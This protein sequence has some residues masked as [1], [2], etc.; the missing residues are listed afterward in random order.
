MDSDDEFLFLAGCIID[1]DG[2]LHA[3]H[4]GNV[5]E[6]TEDV[7]GN[8]AI[9]DLYKRHKISS[10]KRRLGELSLLKLKKG[11][12]DADYNCGMCCD[13]LKLLSDVTNCL[14]AGQLQSIEAIGF[15]AFLHSDDFYVPKGFI[16]WICSQF[17]VR[18]S[19]LVLKDKVIPFSKVTVHKILG[20][21]I[22]GHKVLFDSE[23][24]EQ[25]LLQMLDLRNVES[26]K[27]FGDKLVAKE[28]LSDDQFVLCFMVIAISSLFC[29]NHTTQPVTEALAAFQD[30]HEVV[31]FDWAL[32]VHSK[33]IE[34]VTTFPKLCCKP[35]EDSYCF[36]VCAY[37]LAVF[38]LDCV[39][40]GSY[41]VSQQIPRISFW[42]RSM[43]Y[44]NNVDINDLRVGNSCSCAEFK[45]ILESLYGSV[46]PEELKL[47]VCKI[48]EDHCVQQAKNHQISS[49]ELIL[50]IFS[51]CNELSV[52]MGNDKFG[53]SDGNCHGSKSLYDEKD[54][55]GGAKAVH[56]SFQNHD[57][58]C[59]PVN[60]ENHL[61]QVAS[62]DD[63]VDLSLKIGVQN[64]IANDGVDAVEVNL[65]E[66]CRPVID[67]STPGFLNFGNKHG[68]G[69]SS[70]KVQ[71]PVVKQKRVA[72]MQTFGNKVHEFD[73]NRSVSYSDVPEMYLHTPQDCFMPDITSSSGIK[74]APLLFGKVYSS[75]GA[76]A[77]PEANPPVFDVET[78]Q[79]VRNRDNNNRAN[80]K[81]VRKSEGF[82]RD[83]DKCD[84]AIPVS[85]CEMKKQNARLCKSTVGVLCASP[86]VPEQN[87]FM[88]MGQK[89]VN[90]NPVGYSNELQCEDFEALN[91]VDCEADFVD[92]HS[93]SM[94]S[95]VDQKKFV[96]V[97]DVDDFDN[98][99]DVNGNVDDDVEFVR[100]V[101]FESKIR[102]L[103]NK[104]EMLDNRTC[105]PVSKS[106]KVDKQK[107][108]YLAACRLASSTR[109]ND[110]NAVEI[111]GCF[112][113][114]RELGNSLRTG[115]KVGSYVINAL[116]RKFFLDKRPTI[117]RKHYF[118]S[119]I[120]AILLKG[121]GNLS[122]V[123][124]CFDGAASVLELHKADM[125]LFPICH[126]D[127]WFVFIV[128][129]KNSLFVFLDSYYSEEDDY[130]IFVRSN[131]IP[132]F[133]RIWKELVTG[134]LDFENY[135]VVYPAVPKQS[136]ITDCGVFVIM[137]LTFWTWYCG[138]CIEFTQ[139]DIDNIRIHTVSDLVC[140][141]H[142]V[143]HS[144]PITNYFGE[145]SFPRVGEIRKSTVQY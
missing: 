136:N 37:V 25:F 108:N 64:A 69:S 83:L 45:S 103:C 120:G 106:A 30:L 8:E 96:P 11:R 84:S 141:E 43:V 7:A 33:V 115:C 36:G 79:Y 97:I 107:R 75:P 139:A 131:L 92:K 55:F 128:D 1:E 111:G 23:R 144:S 112:V 26:I 32:Y 105:V 24:G 17:D 100:E 60:A 14:S 22:G 94:F 44:W 90:S 57:F 38:Y 40:F 29:F 82:L 99:A 67:L 58:V 65:E 35:K 81:V 53:V 145:G 6:C 114:F 93:K 133:K 77:V 42:K 56:S 102:D 122:Y 9:F 129:I 47:G 52:T 127:H 3:P 143:A 12:K 59:G 140:C 5:N 113:K 87:V 54:L 10:L 119:G 118:F 125:L 15:G 71:S 31:S 130:H 21:P 138:L 80:A 137:F 27:Y 16:S 123:K 134:P 41:E 61:P 28:E 72:N 18:T 104:S 50:R 124:K 110:K 68:S 91:K 62:G 46:L 73:L 51:F 19:E 78:Q 34:F 101:K 76:N 13:C 63:K 20:V 85:D 48:Y 142:N 117:S 98:N 70:V 109:W 86:P 95:K 135:D 126:D 116:C 88:L 89:I 39:N 49:Q 132:N 66:L 2:F 4:C 74:S 121:S